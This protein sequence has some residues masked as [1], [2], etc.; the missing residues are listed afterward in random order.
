MYEKFINELPGN[1]MNTP[2][3]ANYVTTKVWTPLDAINCQHYVFNIPIHYCSKAILG[4]PY[5]DPDYARLRVMARLLSLK[6][7]HPE[8]REKN[9]AYGGGARLSPDG[10][11]T[12]FSYRDPRN[13]QTLDVFDKAHNWLEKELTKITEQ[14]ILEAKLGV[15]QQ[16]DAPI[17]PSNKGINEFL[18]GLNAETLQRHRSEIMSVDRN[19]LQSVSDKY[20]GQDNASSSSKVILGPKSDKMDTGKRTGELWT[21]FE[22]E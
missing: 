15:F 9:G 6:Y 12:F 8:L 1:Q 20:L 11:F 7:L 14:E 22:N 16:V 21:V 4:K 5:T 3:E 13:L 17:I 2:I 10:V 18:R 19:A